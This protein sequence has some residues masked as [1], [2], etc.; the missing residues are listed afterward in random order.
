M[1]TL[2]VCALLT[3]VPIAAA[4]PATITRIDVV[5]KPA[6]YIGKCPANISFIA[7][8]HVSRWPVVIQYQWERSDGTRSRRERV[9]IAG[10]RHSLT[11]LRRIGARR[12]RLRIWERLHVLAPSDVTSR[13]ARVIVRCR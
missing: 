13:Q 4:A 2:L 11:D 1:R 10:A 7:T 6:A 3:G 8:V 9:E 5:A 12:Q